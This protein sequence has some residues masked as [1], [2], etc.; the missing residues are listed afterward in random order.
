MGTGNQTEKGK[1]A[2]AEPGGRWPL[3]CIAVVLV[4]GGLGWWVTRDVEDMGETADRIAGEISLVREQLEAFHEHHG[5]WPSGDEFVWEALV[6]PHPQHTGAASHD[7]EIAPAAQEH[8]LLPPEL[9]LNDET[10][11]PTRAGYWYNPANGRFV[12]RASAT[13]QFAVLEL[14]SEFNR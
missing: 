2:R 14:A 3:E 1:P 5:R 4:V 7:V 9:D 10:G 8:Y 6:S 12:A 13:D 11:A